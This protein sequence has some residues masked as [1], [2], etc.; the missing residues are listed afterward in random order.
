[1]FAHVIRLQDGSNL[2]HMVVSTRNK[3]KRKGHFTHTLCAKRIGDDFGRLG[4]RAITTCT[5]CLNSFTG[6]VDVL[7]MDFGYPTWDDRTGR[8]T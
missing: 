1:M 6:F 7:D 8:F 3:L 4:S 5:T 2:N